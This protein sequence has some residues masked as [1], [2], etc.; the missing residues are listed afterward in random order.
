MTTPKLN[1][2]TSALLT[3]IGACG[4]ACLGTLL[5]NP[6]DSTKAV[7]SSVQ[8]PG[9]ASQ[10]PVGQSPQ[11]VGPRIAANFLPRKFR[12]ESDPNRAKEGIIYPEVLAWRGALRVTR[13]LGED[14]LHKALVEKLDRYLE[15]PDAVHVSQRAHVDYRVFGVLPLEVFLHNRDPRCRELGL[16]LADAQWQATSSDGITTEARYWIDDMYMIPALQAQAF[17]VSQQSVYLDRAAMTMAAYFDR[18]QKENGLFFHGENSPFFWGRGNGWMAAGAADL[19]GV[20]PDDHPHRARILKG[21][22]TMMAA[23]LKFQNAQGLWCQLIDRPESW[24]ET[25]G[26][27]MFTYA[28]IIGAKRGWLDAQVYGPAARKAWLNL[29]QYL[30]ADANLREVCVGTNKGFD[31]PYYLNRARATGDLHGQAPM[32]WCVEAWLE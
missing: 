5:A 20:L 8:A 21:Y 22:R 25:S 29:T 19:L 1:P 17:R 32:L 23:L 6:A 14:P 10:W 11:E 26:S 28:M 2:T 24:T 13:L 16:R 30:D 18:L 12:Y 3:A 9:W 31:E 4:I 15:G 7:T 27:A